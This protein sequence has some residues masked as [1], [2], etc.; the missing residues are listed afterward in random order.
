[1][2]EFRCEIHQVQLM[3]ALKNTRPSLTNPERLKYEQM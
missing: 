2:Q 3:E 1:M